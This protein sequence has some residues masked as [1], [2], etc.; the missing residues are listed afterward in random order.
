MRVLGGERRA[1]DFS[2]A[3]VVEGDNPKT[4]G[5]I[6]VVGLHEKFQSS[7]AAGIQ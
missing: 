7:W 3:R 2:Y 1:E 6:V 5:I 4:S